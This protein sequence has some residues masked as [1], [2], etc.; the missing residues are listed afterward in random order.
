MNLAS[1]D[2]KIEDRIQFDKAMF[3]LGIVINYQLYEQLSLVIEPM[4]LNK[5]GT[6]LTQ[7]AGFTYLAPFLIYFTRGEK[8]TYL[9]R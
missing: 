9:T 5:G 1:M 4:Y 7:E 6:S 8:I 2:V 3:A